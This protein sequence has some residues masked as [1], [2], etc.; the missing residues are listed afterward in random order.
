MVT[1]DNFVK[2]SFAPSSLR[3]SDT[4]LCASQQ[5][6]FL[7][8]A[9]DSGNPLTDNRQLNKCL[10][11]RSAVKVLNQAPPLVAVSVRKI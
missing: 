10:Y 5:N 8:V 9:L 3:L 11:R 6:E 4:H 2:S 1:G 7:S